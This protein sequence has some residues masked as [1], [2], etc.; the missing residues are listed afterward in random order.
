MK[1]SWLTIVTINQKLKYY[2]NSIKKGN[3]RKIIG[4][5]YP[6]FGIL[7]VIILLALAIIFGDGKPIAS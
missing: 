5:F 1:D 3:Y 4:N 6:L 7:L 2:K